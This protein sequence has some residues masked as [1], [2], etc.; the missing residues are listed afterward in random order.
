[1]NV[2]IVPIGSHGDVHPFVGI[3]IKLRERG[4]RV[5]V[6]PSVFGELLE[7]AAGIHSV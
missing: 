1:V 7:Q 2:L 3:G 4:H 6:T 5:R